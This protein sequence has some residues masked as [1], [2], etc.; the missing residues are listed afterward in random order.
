[1]YS[2]TKNRRGKQDGAAKA[3]DEADFRGMQPVPRLT[4]LPGADL[5]SHLPDIAYA[6][7]APLRT[8]LTDL[9]IRFARR[10]LGYLQD[11]GDAA[12]QPDGPWPLR[13]T[14]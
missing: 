7:F 2:S 13:V 3:A 4:A 1:M 8:H 6:P 12:P 9:T 5:D 14:E 11:P 10:Y